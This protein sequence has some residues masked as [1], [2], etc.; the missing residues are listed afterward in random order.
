VTGLSTFHGGWVSA[1]MSAAYL[2]DFRR[3]RVFIDGVE[4]REL[5]PRAHGVLDLTQINLWAMEDAA[6]EQEAEETRLYLRTWRTQLTTPITR[7]DVA[8]GDQQTNLYRGYLARRYDNGAAFQFGAQQ[9]GTTPPN[10]FGSASDQLGIVG[11]VGW[12]NKRWSVDAFASRISR[13]RGVIIGDDRDSIPSVESARTDAYVRAAFG[14]PDTSRAWAQVMASTSKYDYTGVRTFNFASPKTAAESSFAF[15]SLDTAKSRAQYVASI[16]S[17]NGPLKLSASARLYSGLGKTFTVPSLRAS[18]AL[19]RLAVSAYAEGKSI[20]ST[21]R[22]DVSARLT[23]LSFVSVLASAGRTSHELNEDTTYSAMYVRGE[24]GVR[25]RNLWLLGGI[26]R[27]D[28]VQLTPPSIYDTTFTSRWDASATGVTAAIRGQL[29]RLVNADISAVRWNDTAGFY[30][31]R[32]QTR[33]E[34]F[35]KTNLLDRF[36]SNNFGLLFSAVHEY[37][38]GVR[39]PVGKTSSREA[40][41]YRTITTLL[42]IRILNGTLSWQFR[43]LLGERYAQVPFYV[44][45]RQTNFYGVRWEFYN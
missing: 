20:D 2:G 14:D 39:F 4:Q 45:P 35:V 8:T 15:S 25:V 34:L 38:S 40:P 9:Y 18:Y 21:A 1:P 41:G 36:P 43:N 22:F 32:Y 27:R 12:A 26:L 11:R 37:R 19:N 24:A 30:R 3:V 13:H 16:G 28:S 44:S 17:V 23:P 10:I 29:W 7:A 6:I 33:S 31:P 5:D 42:E